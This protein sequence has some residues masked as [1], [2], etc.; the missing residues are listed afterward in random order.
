MTA[1]NEI[2]SNANAGWNELRPM[3]DEALGEL[4]ETDREAIVL[5]YFESYE[6]SLVGAALGVS[7][8]AARM[9]VERALEKLRAVLQKRGVA[10]T[11]A[12]LA[13]ALAESPAAAVPAQLAAGITSAALAQAAATS[14]GSAPSI[15]KIIAM[16]KLSIAAVGAL[17]LS[18]AAVLLVRNPPASNPR[19]DA[20]EAPTAAAQAA[21]VQPG[22]AA[23]STAITGDPDIFNKIVQRH[24][25]QVRARGGQD[26]DETRAAWDKMQA[27]FEDSMKEEPGVKKFGAKIMAT[28]SPGQTLVMTGWRD[29]GGENGMVFVTPQFGTPQGIPAVEEA[30]TIPDQVLIS[31]RFI[32]VPDEVLDGL[33]MAALKAPPN[34]ANPPSEYLPGEQADAMFR[35]ITNTTGGDYLMRPRVSTRVGEQASITIGNEAMI[36]GNPQHLGLR[37]GFLTSRPADGTSLDVGIVVRYTVGTSPE[38]APTEDQ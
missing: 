14:A 34:G 30:G 19:T 23:A 37:M 20:A 21:P 24:D 32:Q 5:R 11:G 22:R 31:S 33:G 15:V 2:N 3:I 38:G 7:E 29:T 17:A 10:T 13:A 35:S 8:N 28:F 18:S 36:A 6:F 9:R 4:G 25:E 1:M 26:T 12:A 16:N 27:D